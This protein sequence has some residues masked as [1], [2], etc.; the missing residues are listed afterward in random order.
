MA[1]VNLA[2]KPYKYTPHELAMGQP[3]RTIL[4]S[5][6]H[7]CSEDLEGITEP[8]DNSFL[9]MLIERQRINSAWSAQL[10]DEAA[11]YSTTA[12]EVKAHATNSVK[13]TLKP[14]AEWSTT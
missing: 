9:T 2:L 14:G 6:R 13:H 3:P 12:R 7:P 10:S 4:T 11:R 8:L 5:V 1:R